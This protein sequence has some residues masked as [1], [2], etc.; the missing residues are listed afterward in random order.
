MLAGVV[1]C[2]GK[3]RRMGRD[4]S[5]IPFDGRP[6][7]LHVADRLAQVA[8]PVLLAPG[9]SGR[10]ITDDYEQLDDAIADAGPLGGIVGALNASPHPLVAVV[11]ADMPLMSPAVLELLVSLHSGEQVVYPMT[12][13]GA[14]P[15]HAVYSIDALPAMGA[16]LKEGRLGMRA[17]LNELSGRAVEA[18]T[19][20]E[21]DPTG[22]FA[23]NVNREEDLAGLRI[24]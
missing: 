8:Q 16:A 1:L 24:G 6:L 18:A 3:S 7:F 17:L 10:L 21:V 5:L 12:A 20:R 22:R 15:L 9:T 4:K 23:L 2:G 14:Q 19:W 13:D 11:A